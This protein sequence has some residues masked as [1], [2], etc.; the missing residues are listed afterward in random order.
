MGILQHLTGY[1]SPSIGLSESVSWCVN[2]GL[3]MTVCFVL[4][5]RKSSGNDTCSTIRTL[6]WSGKDIT[7]TPCC[8]WPRKMWKNQRGVRLVSAF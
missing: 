2:K 3:K 4:N 5:F 6:K 7:G 8:W 1:A